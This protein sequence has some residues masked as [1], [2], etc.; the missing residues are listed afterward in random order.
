MEERRSSKAAVPGVRL[1]DMRDSAREQFTRTATH[2]S[3]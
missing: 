1:E 2:N 3:R